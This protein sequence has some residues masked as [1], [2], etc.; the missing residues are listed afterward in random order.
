MD[1]LDAG[2]EEIST[3]TDDFD[4]R[5]DK[6]GVEGRKIDRE[7]GENADTRREKRARPEERF[8]SHLKMFNDNRL[9]VLRG[10]P[11]LGA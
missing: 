3:D 7:E 4:T 11:Q 10:R 9:E 5:Q 6:I 2:H 8:L 1:D